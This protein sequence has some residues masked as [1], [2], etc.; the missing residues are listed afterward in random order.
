MPVTYKTC[1]WCAGVGTGCEACGGH[2]TIPV[3]T[4]QSEEGMRREAT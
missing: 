3:V 2:G 1:P 4:K